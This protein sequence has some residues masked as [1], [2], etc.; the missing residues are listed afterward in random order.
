MTYASYDDLVTRFGETKLAQLTCQGGTLGKIPDKSV[1]EAVLADATETID[2]YAAGRYLT[3]LSPVPAPVRRWCADMAFYYLHTGTGKVPDDV[4]KM[5]EDALAGLKDMAKGVIAF[6]RSVPTATSRRRERSVGSAGPDIYAG[7]PQRVLR[8]I[9]I[10]ATSGTVTLSLPP[11]F[12]G[13]RQRSRT[14][15]VKSASRSS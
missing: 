6:R 12:P 4:R 13:S 9:S 2:G 5:F 14:S 3:P 10:K 8:V 11:G 1:I 7:K 15:I